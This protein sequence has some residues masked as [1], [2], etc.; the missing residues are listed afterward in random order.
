[1][2]WKVCF[3]EQKWCGWLVMKPSAM[4]FSSYGLDEIIL[5]DLPT[6]YV[7]FTRMLIYSISSKPTNHG[8]HHFQV[9]KFW[10]SHFQV[11]LSGI[12]TV[13]YIRQHQLTD[14]SS[15]R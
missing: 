8:N 10:G 1:M 4:G 13:H 9:L 3:N 15:C 12:I 7:G 6:M 14:Y 5:W 11:N 2:V